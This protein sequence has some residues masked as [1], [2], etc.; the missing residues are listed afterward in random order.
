MRVAEVMSMLRYSLRCGAARQ[1]LLAMLATLL[2]CLAIAL[3]WWGPAKREQ[4]NLQQGI[5]AHRAA[6]VDAARW[7][8]VARA[9]YQAQKIVAQLEKK[10]EFRAGQADL[11]QGIARLASKRGVRVVSQSFDQGKG[12][13]RDAPLYLE[14]GLTGDYGALRGLMGDFATLP[15]WIEVV[16]AR[17][18][19][20]GEG[21]APLKAQ[22]R[23]LT[24]R[25][26]EKLP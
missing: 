8:Q 9:Q 12:A 21:N 20:G 26:A 16:E 25:G 5:D 14:I 11:I 4:M 7:A 6:V 19:R 2:V 17:I 23:L 22:L 3:I 1:G 18:D 10:L 24:Y 15:M 13:G